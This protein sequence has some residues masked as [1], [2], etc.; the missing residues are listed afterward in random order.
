MPIC[1]LFVNP[2]A[3]FYSIWTPTNLGAHTKCLDFEEVTMCSENLE[4]ALII[5]DRPFNDM[6]AYLLKFSA[7]T[8]L[9][10]FCPSVRRQYILLLQSTNT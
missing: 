5:N 9:T 7:D 10:V 1:D 6:I 4:E 2:K 8:R 3:I